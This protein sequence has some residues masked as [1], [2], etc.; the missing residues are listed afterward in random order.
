M[1]R[2]A[3]RRMAADADLLTGTVSENRGEAVD[4]P[5]DQDAAGSEMPDGEAAG[6]RLSVRRARVS[7]GL[8]AEVDERREVKLDAKV[9]V[10][11]ADLKAC[12]DNM[13]STTD[14]SGAFG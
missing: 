6:R 2:P 13:V 8:R 9:L 5:G 4:L 7:H 3:L 11:D 12:F 14:P 10:L 1:I